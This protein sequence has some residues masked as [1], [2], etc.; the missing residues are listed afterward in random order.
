MERL[1]S[2][3]TRLRDLVREHQDESCEI[4]MSDL[5]HAPELNLDVST[6][7]FLSAERAFAYVDLYA[8]LGRMHRDTVA[9]LTPHAAVALERGMARN[10]W[11]YLQEDYSF[12][13]RADGKTIVAMARSAEALAEIC[14]IIWP[15]LLANASEFCELE[16]RSLGDDGQAFF[17]A[18]SL[19]LLIE[20]CQN[21]EVLTLGVL[22]SA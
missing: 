13:F 21:L 6:G 1:F 11:V 17:S 9:W 20:R 3:C 16:F 12:Y 4:M 2:P 5:V 8:M 22:S 19:A 15:L 14:D 7:A 10:L 18:E